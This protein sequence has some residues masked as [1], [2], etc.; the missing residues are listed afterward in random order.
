M[1]TRNLLKYAVPLAVLVAI[2]ATSVVTAQRGP[3]GFGRFGPGGPGMFPPGPPA[4]VAIMKATPDGVFVLAGTKLV[5][6]DPAT[7]KQLGSLHSWM[8]RRTPV[9]A[10]RHHRERRLRLRR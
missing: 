2:W 3:R 5:K 10:L 7:L 4:P 9:P 8:P 6:Y 1:K